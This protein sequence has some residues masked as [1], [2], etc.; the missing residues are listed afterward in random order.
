MIPT[1]SIL[2]QNVYVAQTR[3]T[4]NEY[5]ILAQML[6]GKRTWGT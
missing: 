3:E 5:E 4:R 2:K 1:S 6:E